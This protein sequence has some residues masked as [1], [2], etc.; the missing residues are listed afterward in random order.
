M[1]ADHGFLDLNE[2]YWRPDSSAIEPEGYVY[3]HSSA[4]SSSTVL[5][6]PGSGVT[7]FKTKL[8]VLDKFTNKWPEPLPLKAVNKRG[9]QDEWDVSDAELEKSVDALL[10]ESG[11]GPGGGRLGL[12]WF[13]RWTG[14][15]WSLLFSVLSVLVYG[16]AGLSCAIAI[17]FRS[18]YLF[19]ATFCTTKLYSAY[20]QLGLM[21]M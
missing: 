12:E 18:A 2:V 19:T 16:I 5:S 4:A 21:Q 17:W 7:R 8:G 14:F 20:Y 10:L 9:Y 11:I 6:A 1:P 15:K 13:S 3:S